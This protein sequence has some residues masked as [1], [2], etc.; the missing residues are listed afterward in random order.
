MN[1]D[2]YA[3]ELENFKRD[4]QQRRDWNA[5]ATKCERQGVCPYSGEKFAVCKKVLCDC[6]DYDYEAKVQYWERLKFWFLNQHT[7]PRNWHRV[8]AWKLWG[9]R[10]QDRWA[11]QYLV[12]GSPDTLDGG[13]PDSRKEPF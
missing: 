3:E 12:G 8:A 4:A 5:H 9:K 2:D 6:F 10:A 7:S 13:A 11:D 1:A